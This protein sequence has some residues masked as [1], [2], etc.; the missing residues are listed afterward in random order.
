MPIILRAE[1]SANDRHCARPQGGSIAS[2][3]RPAREIACAA[4][5]VCVLAGFLIAELG[6]LARGVGATARAE[7]RDLGQALGPRDLAEE[8]EARSPLLAGRF[9]EALRDLPA[10]IAAHPGDPDFPYQLA[11]VYLRLGRYAEGIPYALKACQNNP[12][13]ILY[14]WMLRVLTLLAGRPETTIPSEYRVVL[15]APAP[16]PVHFQDVTQEAGVSHF[17]LG[18]GVAWGDFDRDG[19]EDLL[20]CAERAPF[21]LF[22]NLSGG[23]FKDVA[24]QVGLVDPVGLGCYNASF[25][26]YDND[27]YEDVFLTS[28][29]W[30]GVNRLFLF[31]NDPGRRFTDVTKQ[32]GLGGSF[33]A[34]GAA[35]ADYDNDG[36]LDLA[37]AT[38]IIRRGGE[39]LRLF[40][41]NGTGKFSEV[42]LRSGL[43]ETQNWISACWGDYDGDGYADLV[44]TSFQGSSLFRNLGD[45]HFENVTLS[46]GIGDPIISYTCEFLDYN[47]DGRLDLFISTY[48]NHNVSLVVT[49]SRLISGT[50]ALLGDRQLLYQNNG[51]G[52]FTL[53]T[54]QAGILGFIHGMASQVADV[55]NDGY[56]DILIGVGNPRL[57]WAEPQVLYHNDGNGHFT[58][59]AQSAGFVDYGKLHGIA[60]SDID[61]SGNLSFYASFGGFYWGDR[62]KARLFRNRGAG[63]HA[64]EVRLVGTRS[65]RNAVGARLVARVGKRFIYR[66]QDGGSGF[67]SMNSRIVHIGLGASREVD[68]L[69][70]L[71]P[72]GLSQ[73]FRHILSD[74]RIEV[75]EGS[76]DI[77]RLLRF[78]RPQSTS[79]DFS[80]QGG[81]ARSEHRTVRHP[82]ERR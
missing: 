5:V 4:T 29:G 57:D 64:L 19:R 15:P 1:W 32:A 7:S 47:N 2:D 3:S 28:N 49:V 61:D 71:W 39:R 63:N 62:G 65:N 13:G 60:F 79:V 12:K 43:R 56:P 21:R 25:V 48:P 54:E 81:R 40:H 67:G 51:D 9:D 82:G 30:G 78:K 73:H 70:I 18:R 33:N 17:A 6:P 20:V 72:S 37:V 58:D 23:K 41:N 77:R 42:G 10:Q 59:I 38:G 66:W 36:N 74:Q 68:S 22:R 31:H 50:P 46:A 75:I 76:P 8:E 52:T 26:D 55:D 45:S 27:G 14:H 44:A 80:S 53:A 24:A 35:W 69:E 11:T 16:S 34:F